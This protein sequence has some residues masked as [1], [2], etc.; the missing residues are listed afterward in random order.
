MTLF[1][2]AD[3]TPAIIQA[4]KIVQA[5]VQGTPQDKHRTAFAPGPGSGRH[6]CGTLGSDV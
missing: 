5:G 3:I 6:R 2:R 1:R 4:I